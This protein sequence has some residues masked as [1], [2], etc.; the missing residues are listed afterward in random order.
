MKKVVV[1]T[2]AIMLT[3]S[4]YSCGTGTASNPDLD[5]ALDGV[6]NQGNDLDLA[7]LAVVAVKDGEVVYQYGGG[8]QR[9]DNE[10]EENNV[11]FESSTR[12]R[13]AS[14]SKT[15]VAVGIMQLV[16]KGKID[17]DQDVSKYLG[18]TLRNPNY[19]DTPI[20]C[21]MLLSHTSS[22]RDGTEGKEVYCIEPQYGLNEFFDKDGKYYDSGN[23]FAKTGQAPGKYF[24]YANMNYSVLGTIIEC[25]SEERFDQYMT[26]HIFEPM[27]IGASFNVS[28]FDQDAMNNLATGYKM[29]W[30]KDGAPI[31]GSKWIATKDDY[32]GKIQ[33]KD[34]V[35]IANPDGS[36]NPIKTNIKNYKIGT[37]ASFFSPA[38]GLRISA[39]ELAAY[40]QMYINDGVATSGERILS[41]ESVNQMFTPQWTWNGKDKGTNGDSEYG[42]MACWGLG[43]HIITNGQYNDGYG[44][45]F[46]KDRKDLNLVGHYGDAYNMFS[47]F[48]VDREGKS[49]FTYVCNGAACDIYSEIPYGEYSENWIWEEQIV[50]NLYKYI[51]DEK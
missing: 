13:I 38:G 7:G 28:D 19:P 49:G 34:Y 40:I 14:V 8:Y 23:H 24:S 33:D 45:T 30:D 3:F 46:L 6:V 16:E 18:F 5:K 37:N 44:D 22:L 35:I 31:K 12:M 1:I 15:F 4:L 47:L 25:A 42:L 41:K 17:L 27:D 20:T 11:P 48:M 39:D 21:R 51:F 2:L 50:T 32:N 36:D 43:L 26:K 9:I 10:D 29:N